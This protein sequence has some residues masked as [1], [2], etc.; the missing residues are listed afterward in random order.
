MEIFSQYFGCIADKPKIFPDGPTVIYN[1][2]DSNITLKCSAEGN[3]LPELAWTHNGTEVS[4]QE[5]SVTSENEI[6][7]YIKFTLKKRELFGNYSC[8][9]KNSVGMD[10][11]VVIIYLNGKFGFVNVLYLSLLHLL[12]YVKS[13]DVMSDL[14]SNV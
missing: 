2:L 11:R 4:K 3:P 10:V 13:Y 9:A 5:R 14:H 8:K 12:F 1:N 6:E 7:T